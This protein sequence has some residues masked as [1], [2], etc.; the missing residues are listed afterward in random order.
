MI[1]PY[2]AEQNAITRDIL[3]RVVE[4]YRRILASKPEIKQRPGRPIYLPVRKL[5][6]KIEAMTEALKSL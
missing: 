4:P 3:E 5:I 2:T 1:E 6:Q